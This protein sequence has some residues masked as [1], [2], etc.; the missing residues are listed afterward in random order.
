MNEITITTIDEIIEQLGNYTGSWIFEDGKIKDGVLA[1]DTREL[2][3][4]FKEFEVDKDEAMEMCKNLVSLHGDDM[5]G[6]FYG[7]T[8]GNISH[9]SDNSYNWN[10]SLS[11]DI[12][13]NEFEYEYDGEKYVA[14]MVHLTGDV[15]ANYSYY[16]ILHCSFDDLLNVEF[17]PSID[18]GNNM[19]ADLRWYSDTYS[20]YNYETNEDVGEFYISEV[21]ELLKAIKE[22]EEA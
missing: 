20:V 12:N 5:F 3:K 22:K 15:R 18:I 1:I 17:Y 6:M 21:D 14:I 7:F 2:L 9:R 8:F 19:I 4:E 13:F 16:V 10:S 11:H